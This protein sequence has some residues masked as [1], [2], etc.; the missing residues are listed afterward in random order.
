MM[1]DPLFLRSV[2]LFEDLEDGDLMRVAERLSV[3]RY[4]KNNLIIFEEDEGQV[5]FVI[6]S[7]RV[8]I[9]RINSSGEEVILAILGPADFFGELSIVD[10]GPRS[11]TVTSLEEVELLSLRRKDFFD[12][13][14]SHPSVAITLLKLMA[15]RI[16]KTD[17]QLVSLSSLD[18]RG[19]VINTLVHLCRDLGRESGTDMILVNLPL[20]RDLASMAG[21]SRETMSR[22][23]ARLESE[24]WLERSGSDLVVHNFAEFRKLH[25]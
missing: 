20:Q 16:R 24:G 19:R 7:G 21:T 4:R 2:I 1:T 23:L 3:K 5:L 11:A 18:A 17:A 25:G 13:L 9:S 14:Q 22:L 15:G 10:G 6:R 12:I 8:K